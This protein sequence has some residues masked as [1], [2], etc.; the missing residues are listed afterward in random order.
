MFK[1][2]QVSEKGARSCE[3]DLEWISQRTSLVG[4][5]LS[6]LILSLHAHWCQA[7]TSGHELPVS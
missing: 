3:L 6:V 2:V 4:R 1:E 5:Q 7:C